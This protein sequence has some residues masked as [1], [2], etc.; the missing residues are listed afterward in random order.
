MSYKLCSCALLVLQIMQKSNLDVV[1][2]HFSVLYD[3]KVS[4]KQKRINVLK[5][6]YS[7]RFARILYSTPQSVLIWICFVCMPS[8]HG[9]I[10]CTPSKKCTLSGD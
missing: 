8:Y 10:M 1:L 3:G 5:I 6:L 7:L 2:K 9:V 4:D